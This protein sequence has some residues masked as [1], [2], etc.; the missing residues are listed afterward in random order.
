MNGINGWQRIGVALTVLWL[1]VGSFGFHIW[2]LRIANEGASQAFENCRWNNSSSFALPQYEKDCGKA[3][4]VMRVRLLEGEFTRVL[5]S[6]LIPIPVIW[7]LDWFILK[8]TTWI[9][10]GFKAEE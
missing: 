2:E 3:R 4:E 7:L 10:L 8:T 6:V 1:P 9:R 5:G